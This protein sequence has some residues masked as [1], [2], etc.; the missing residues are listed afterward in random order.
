MQRCGIWVHAIL[1]GVFHNGLQGQRR[2]AKPGVRRI[3]VNEKAILKLNLLHGKVCAGVLQFVG[4]GNG[5]PAGDG[6]EV[7]AE[8]GG[9]IH[10]DTLGFLG[11]LIAEI[12]DARHGVVDEVRPH[13]QHHDAGALMGDLPLLV[14]VLFHLIGQDEAV[15]GQGGEDRAD[16]DQRV[17]VDE[18]MYEHRDRHGQLGDEQAQPGFA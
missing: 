6:S 7:P 8:V 10:R 4:K 5:I 1:D 17:D 2:H 11:V 16:V 3:V 15:H 12:V 18:N 9:K 14:H 13:L